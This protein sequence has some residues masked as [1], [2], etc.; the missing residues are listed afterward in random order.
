LIQVNVTP[1]AGGV[2]DRNSPYNSRGYEGMTQMTSLTKYEHQVLHK[3][4]DQL[5]H[6]ESVEDV[7]KFFV[8]TV[9][10]FL[11][12]A[13]DGNIKAH[14]EDIALL[15]DKAP[16]YSLASQIENSDAIKA[17]ANS[18]LDAVLERIA[19]QAAHR[20]KHLEKNPLKTNLKIKG[21]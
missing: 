1:L 12:L 10:D 20:H 7:K 13:T 8:A 3:L 21:H 14:Y 9:Q 6:S 17:L 4:R 5:N 2:K 19:E 18:D 16:Y 15:P 11:E